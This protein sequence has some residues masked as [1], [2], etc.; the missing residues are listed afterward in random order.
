MLENPQL[1]NENV[2]INFKIENFKL[3]LDAN[4]QI[5]DELL[6]INKDEGRPP[7]HMYM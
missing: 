3:P 6:S 2:K 1:N 4:V 7:E 5:I